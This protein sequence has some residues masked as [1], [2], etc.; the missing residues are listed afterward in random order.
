[1]EPFNTSK[2]EH[3]GN[4]S[5]LRCTY[6]LIIRLFLDFYHCEGHRGHAFKWKKAL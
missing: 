3:I 2:I 1:M 4:V 5:M 6:F